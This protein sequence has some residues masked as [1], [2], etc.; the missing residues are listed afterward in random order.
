MFPPTPSGGWPQNASGEWPPVTPAGYSHRAW[1][2]QPEASS[3]TFDDLESLDYR[4][5]YGYREFDLNTPQEIEQPG[6]WQQATPPQN[7]DSTFD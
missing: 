6:W 7:T 1:P 4:Q 2:A 5:N 3:S